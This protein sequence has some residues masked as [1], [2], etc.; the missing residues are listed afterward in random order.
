MPP[1]VAERAGHLDD[2]KGLVDAFLRKNEKICSVDDVEYD[3]DTG[4]VKSCFAE[5]VAMR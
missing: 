4:K 2:L 1:S 5:L 3:Y